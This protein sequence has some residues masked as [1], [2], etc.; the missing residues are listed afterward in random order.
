MFNCELWR[1][2][3]SIG[4]EEEQKI[5]CWDPKPIED[6]LIKDLGVGEDEHIEIFKLRDEGSVGDFLG[7]RIDK[8]A[9]NSFKLSQTDLIEKFIKALYQDSTRVFPN[10]STGIYLSNL[11]EK[12]NIAIIYIHLLRL[13]LFL[14]LLAFTCIGLHR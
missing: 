5:I 11:A 1:S 13:Y 14:L 4:T 8:C 7:I 2:V 9:H 6:L 12:I 3:Q 10:A